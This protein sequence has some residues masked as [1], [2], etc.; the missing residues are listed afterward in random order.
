MENLDEKHVDMLRTNLSVY[1]VEGIQCQLT[2]QKKTVTLEV[3]K[4]F[5]PCFA[6]YELVIV[7]ISGN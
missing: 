2:F 4:E 3:R 5:I 6:F 7:F 1:E